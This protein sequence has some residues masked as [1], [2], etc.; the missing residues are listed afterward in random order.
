MEQSL[1][2]KLEKKL[3]EKVNKKLG[4]MGARMDLL[5]YENVKLREE[6]DY[7]KIKLGDSEVIARAAAQKANLNEQYSRKNNIKI[8]G[9][10]EG[11]ETE[12]SLIR[13]INCILESKT[14]I[15]L[16][17]SKILA[18]HRIPGKSGMPK[19]VLIKLKNNSE[20]TRLLEKDAK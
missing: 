4:D 1:Q 6:V 16:D 17:D 13:K 11:E 18:I 8:M 15:S 19:P 7:L 12:E 20:K 9:V 14:G 2:N 10:E 3:D 5:T